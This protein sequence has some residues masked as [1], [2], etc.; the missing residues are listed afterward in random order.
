MNRQRIAD[1]Y[2][3]WWPFLFLCTLILTCGFLEGATR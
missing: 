1:F 3:N 2:W